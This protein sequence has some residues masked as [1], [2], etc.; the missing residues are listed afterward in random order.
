MRIIKN[1]RFVFVSR[2]SGNN[3]KQFILIA[4]DR[5]LTQF[6]NVLSKNLENYI[7]Y[8][9]FIAAAQSHAHCDYGGNL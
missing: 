5:L 7:L 8:C 4:A 2:N 1:I 3:R 6:L 9:L